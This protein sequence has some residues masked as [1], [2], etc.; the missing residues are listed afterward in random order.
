MVVSWL[1]HS[2][3]TS[4]R[5]SILWMDNAVDI[6]KDLKARYSQGDFLRI[7][8]LQ[9][10][11]ASIKHL[12]QFV[13]H[14]SSAHQQTTYRSLRYLKATP[15]SGVFFS[16]SSIFLLKAFSDS[17]WAGCIDTKRSITSYSVYLG[18]SLISWKSKKQATIS[19][20]SF[21]VEYRALASAT[22]E[23]Q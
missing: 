9:H 21:E 3:A 1:V 10:K 8:D 5:Q 19:K 13:A 18:S 7:S 6:W 15:G 16:T 2:V 20:S 17:D 22:Y 12:S 14:P 11:L 4:I 23:L